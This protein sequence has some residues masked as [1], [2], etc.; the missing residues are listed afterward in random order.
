MF[1]AGVS[2]TLL[3]LIDESHSMKDMH[4]KTK[5]IWSLDKSVLDEN[6]AQMV[7]E[8]HFGA[9][10][11]LYSKTSTEQM[12]EF[13]KLTYK[14][15]KNFLSQLPVMLD[16]SQLTR[17]FV[18]EFTCSS[19]LLY[20]Q[21]I[22]LGLNTNQG[23]DIQID[24]ENPDTFII[25]DAIIY[26]GFGSVV[27][28]TSK[29]SGN[30]IEAWVV[31]GGSLI[32]GMEVHVP[33][34]RKEP[35][36]FDLSH[37]DIKAFKSIGIDYVI[38]PS[39]SSAKEISLIRKKINVE[40][41]ENPWLILRIDN[42]TV[43]ENLDKLLPLV[44]GVMISRRELALTIEAAMVPVACKEIIQQCRKHAKLVI[45]ASEMLASMRHNP[46]PTRAEVSDVANAVI[47]GTDA[48][49]L[50]EEIALGKYTVRS[51]KLCQS[52][53]EDVEN[54]TASASTWSREDVQLHNELDAV[55][56]HAFK[57]AE[58]V[59]AKAIVCIT[60]SGNTAFRLASFQ[61]S[62]PIIAV[63]FKEEI[64]RKLKLIRGVVPLNLDINPHLDEVLPVVK[65]R[66]LKD[67]WLE[68]GDYIVFV[69]VSLSSISKEASN[70]FT[71]QRL[72]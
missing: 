2:K 62:M 56:Y 24:C 9:L 39:I 55:A 4:A 66:L 31:Q 20:E 6:Q 70:L 44:E 38:L 3:K 36:V 19:E 34:T 33:E 50:S 16:V 49:I 72:E 42:K 53:L 43:V 58:R 46:T 52:I 47:D 17:A 30:K 26:L 45:I 40:I 61:V 28:K 10:R 71:V 23:V 67:G 11:L 27:L 15:R 5:I 1:R 13:L 57:T 41:N 48:I 8:N 29:V 35:T 69:T 51:F 65:E 63:T 21:K 59:K 32:A 25:P 54:Q 12:V 37:V 7:G 22:T 64:E 18:K 14:F 68:K 60:K